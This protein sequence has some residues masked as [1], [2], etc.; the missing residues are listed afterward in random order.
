MVVLAPI[1]IS[2]GV[3]FVAAR[4]IPPPVSSLGAYLGWWI[5]LSA[6]A[7]LVLSAAGRI[8]RRFLP[9]VALL[10]LSLV[11]PD[12]AP[13]RFRTAMRLGTLETLE[14]RI[15]EAK[16]GRHDA[17]PAEAAE[18]LL[19]L[20]AALDRH[21]GLTRGHS[22]RVRAYSQTIGRQ[23]GLTTW[24]LDALNWAALLH[25]IGKLEVPREILAKDG[26]PS[27]EEWAILRR[28]PELGEPFTEP[29]RDWL[30][31]WC[32]AVVDHHERWDG[33]GYPHGK[34][35][36]DI[37]LA[38]RIV[39]VA[40][41]FDVIT[42]S[43]SY[44]Q[45]ST[46]VAARQELTRCAGTQFDP[47]VVRAFLAVSLERARPATRIL[48]WLAHAPI[49]ARIPA[50]AAGTLS[51]AVVV[52][53]STASTPVFARDGR[54]TH[55]GARATTRV[56]PVEGLVG[57]S[58]A[59]PRKASAGLR[60]PPSSREPGAPTSPAADEPTRSTPAPPS[61][62]GPLPPP[63][64]TPE[65]PATPPPAPGDT[66][67]RPGQPVPAPTPPDPPPLPA[68]ELPPLPGPEL[69]PLPSPELPPPPSP[70]VPSPPLPAVPTTETPSLPVPA[71]PSLPGG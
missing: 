24:E 7:T 23:L 63:T 46:I 44:K 55:A 35:G 16:R 31:E 58:R 65:P 43:R 52:A 64:T 19:V 39:A 57:S 30:G 5:A 67:P 22:E 54:G 36:R 9:L 11:F 28:H 6:A 17:T 33:A 40:D 21:D 48:S 26:P 8:W 61:D 50:T 66:V 15:A 37:S 32:D 62:N 70:E 20:V 71:L 12:G 51:A 1:A 38:G 53:S 13:S 3:V 2:T 29:L 49:L 68:P 59:R 56:A 60:T 25:D 18:R 45:A 10:R 41:V 69:P 42:S 14:E 34:A 47:E 27:D 4:T